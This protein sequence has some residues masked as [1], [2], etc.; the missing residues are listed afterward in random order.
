MV[1]KE[2]NRLDQ[3]LVEHQL[4][5]SRTKAVWMIEEG[6]IW[7]NGNVIKQKSARVEETDRIEV[8]PLRRIYVSQGGYKLE[9]AILNFKLDFKGKKVLDIGSSTGGFTDCALQHGAKEIVAID[10]G[11]G[12]L[13]ASLVRDKRIHVFE[14]T[15]IRTVNPSQ[16]PVSSYDFILIDVS[17]ISLGHVFP[18][19]HKFISEQTKIIALLKPQFEQ[20]ERRKFKGGIIK[21]SKVRLSIIE[22]VQREII[23]QGFE[24]EGMIET[25]ADPGKKNIEFLLLL[26]LK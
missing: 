20:K 25:D 18:H 21:E 7:V 5:E 26:K 2:T 11:S 14:N 8:K 13:H 6:W 17:F 24:V 4:A 22:S 15:D 1:P 3:F 10:V 23:N 16:L 12:Q 19:L 9:K